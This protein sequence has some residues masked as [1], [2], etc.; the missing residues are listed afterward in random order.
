M[1]FGS[2]ADYI[3]FFLVVS[4]WNT[5]QISK[6]Y[7]CMFIAPIRATKLSPAKLSTFLFLYCAA[8]DF[9]NTCFLGCLSLKE[10]Q[11]LKASIIIC[12]VSELLILIGCM[13]LSRL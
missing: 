1:C 12:H 8:V 5:Q 7:I 9:Q 3:S 11:A 6:L 2:L 10:K 13:C 4:A